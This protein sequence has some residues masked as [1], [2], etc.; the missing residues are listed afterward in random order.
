MGI[1]HW[2]IKPE[3]LLIGMDGYVRLSDFGISWKWEQDNGNDSS[4][5]PGYMAPEVMMWENHGPAA[6]FYGLG[7]IC[8]EIING[9]RPFYGLQKQEL[10]DAIMQS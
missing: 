3:N 5:T 4:G 2:D 6:D 1:L 9:K 10:R 7:I 8:Y